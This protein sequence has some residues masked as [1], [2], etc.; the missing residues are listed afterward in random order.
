MENW[1]AHHLYNEAS[2][3]LGSNK[4]G[5]LQQYAQSLRSKG[6]PVVFSLNHLAQICG[7]TYEF[8]RD[9]VNRE[10]ESSNYRMYA[11][12]KRSGGRRIIHAVRSNLLSVQSFINE[13]ILQKCEPH[14][15]SYAFHPTG[16]IRKCAAAHC[17]ARFLF[18][19]DLTDFFYDVTEIDVYQIFNGLGYRKLVAFEL[20]RLCTTTRLPRWQPHSF[21]LRKTDPVILSMIES[22]GEVKRPY[23]RHEGQVA[24]LPQGA[25]SSPMLANLAALKLD[26]ALADYASLNGFVYSRYA[27]DITVSATRL[28]KRRGRVYSEIVHLIQKSG[29]EV[30]PEKTRIAGPGS[31][32]LVLGLLVDGTQ[33]R[34]SRETY[35]RIDG[36]LHVASKYGLAAAADH[37]GFESAYGFHN[38]LSGLV[39]YVKD[40]DTKRWHEFSERLNE[41]KQQKD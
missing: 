14:S 13:A 7:V 11:V 26:H 31:K 20:A 41:I 32:K 35:K 3:T 6:L 15:S 4:A 37:F 19:F 36:L 28:Q 23:A 33:P 5:Q 34:L 8:L 12:A 1:S 10:R 38:H 9:T 22:E 24:V 30:N 16:G 29:F 17:G 21:R 27:D 18:Q 2:K 25:P 39:A 40:V